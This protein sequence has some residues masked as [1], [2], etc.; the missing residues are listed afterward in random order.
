MCRNQ[1]NKGWN[2]INTNNVCKKNKY[3]SPYVQITMKLKKESS[4]LGWLN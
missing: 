4:K 1:E 2:E 3:I